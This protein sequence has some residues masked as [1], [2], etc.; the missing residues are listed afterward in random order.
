MVLSVQKFFQMLNFGDPT[1][2]SAPSSSSYRS[3][4]PPN[5][6]TG[7]GGGPPTS[8]GT[9]DG[10]PTSQS[11]N[12][13]KTPTSPFVDSLQ[14]SF[15]GHPMYNRSGYQSSPQE[16]SQRPPIAPYFAAAGMNTAVNSPY[17][18]YPL[19]SYPNVP[20]QC[21]S[22]PI[23]LREDGLTGELKFF[24]IF[25]SSWARDFFQNIR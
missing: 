8:D 9:I 14:P 19:G 15:P 16:F 18:S 24:E 6:D 21:G 11:N 25:A 7:G 20:N 23:G 10:P 22:P 4:S 13:T 2:T 5:M 12:N 17:T 1:P 3:V